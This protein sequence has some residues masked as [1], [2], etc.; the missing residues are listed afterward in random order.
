MLSLIWKRRIC[1][2]LS[3]WSK[4]NLSNVQSV[5]WMCPFSISDSIVS[6]LSITERQTEFYSNEN[7]PC[8]KYNQGTN[9][10]SILQGSSNFMKCS[11]KEIWKL[12]KPKINCSVVGLELFFDCP[13]EMDQCK[14]RDEAKMT[15][16]SYKKLFY[17]SYS[18]FWIKTCKLPCSQ[19][20]YSESLFKKVN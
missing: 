14:T 6:E 16:D 10:N 8:K 2:P 1:I 20:I 18:M 11:R 9:R 12:L 7:R 13:N 17:Y 19:V 15:L 4:T 5:M 3:E